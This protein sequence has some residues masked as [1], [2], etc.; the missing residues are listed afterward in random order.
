MQTILCFCGFLSVTFPLSPLKDHGNTLWL[1][2]S[3][4]PTEAQQVHGLVW[5]EWVKLKVRQYIN[6]QLQQSTY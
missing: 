3:P 5:V 6:L 2:L 1:L 4:T